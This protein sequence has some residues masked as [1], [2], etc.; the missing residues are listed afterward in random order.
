M[1]KMTLFI[2]GLVLVFV[3]IIPIWPYRKSMGYAMST[4]IS[5]IIMILIVLLLIGND[6]LTLS[7]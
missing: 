7:I 2:A 6:M 4:S 3:G 5:V 1:S